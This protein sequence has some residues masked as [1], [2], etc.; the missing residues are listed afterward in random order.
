MV[1]ALDRRLVYTSSTT[2]RR[3]ASS[4]STPRRSGS[5]RTP[6][7]GSTPRS[8]T[9]RSSTPRR[10]QI[11]PRSTKAQALVAEQ[12][13]RP[14]VPEDMRTFHHPDI[15]PGTRL[16]CVGPHPFGLSDWVRSWP[17][18]RVMSAD[19]LKARNAKGVSMAGLNI[20]AQGRAGAGVAPEQ[21][22]GMTLRDAK[23]RRWHAEKTLE[24]MTHDVQLTGS[25][26]AQAQQVLQQYASAHSVL[27]DGRARFL[28]VTMPMTGP[29][30]KWRQ[31]LKSDGIAHSIP[32]QSVPPSTHGNGNVLEHG[33]VA[34]VKH[35]DGSFHSI[36]H[37][38][39]SSFEHARFVRSIPPG[40]GGFI[41]NEFR[42]LNALPR[43]PRYVAPQREVTS[44]EARVL[45]AD[46]RGTT[47]P[48]PP[49][50]KPREG[51]SAAMSAGRTAVR[52]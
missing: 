52:V 24:H 36:R 45:S 4:G 15:S 20:Q 8:A 13:E 49:P 10:Q 30:A 22:T 42:Q 46:R 27:G 7:S 38:D 40:Y 37:F 48:P 9:P 2:P 33:A 17:S 14:P 11:A 50:P 1:Q 44:K 25:E 16:G 19:E 31:P 3:S 29:S 51:W 35:P 28:Q 39:P 23:R 43:A 26:T 18:R 12:S 5:T 47:P 6:H 41:P 21:L 32:L 34:T